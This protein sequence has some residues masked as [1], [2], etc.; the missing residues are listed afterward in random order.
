MYSTVLSVP[1]V[2]KCFVFLLLPIL[3]EGMLSRL[4]L[5]KTK[6]VWRPG[7]NRREIFDEHLNIQFT[8]DPTIW[9]HH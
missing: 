5:G 7:S 8:V 4:L 1:P 9:P 3:H 2:M 6:L